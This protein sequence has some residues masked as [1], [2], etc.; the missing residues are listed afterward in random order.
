MSPNSNNLLISE[1][2]R[3]YRS[4]ETTPPQVLAALAAKAAVQPHDP[5]WILRFA[6]H[7]IGAQLEALDSA[8]KLSGSDWAKFPLYGIPFAIKDNIDYAGQQ[9]TAAC[10]QF[11]Y[12]PAESATVVKRL[13]AAGAICVGKTNLDQFATGLNGTRSPYGAV[14]NTFNPLYVSGG[15]SSG[16]AS[17]VARGLVSFSLGTDTAGSGRVP[18]G[19]NNIVGLKPTKGALST[20]GVVPACRSQDCV[21]IFAL[22]ASDAQSV[23]TA[24][25]GADAA[26]IYSR[27]EPKVPPAG[28]TL[29]ANLRV[30]VPQDPEFCGDELAAKS[31]AGALERMQALGAKLVPFDLKPF[32]EVARLLYEGPWVAERFAAIE[33]MFTTKPE[34]IHPVV[35]AVIEK[36]RN[37]TAVDT[38]NAMYRLEALRRQ[39]APMWDQ[40]D[41]M[42]V[43]TSPTIYT[44]EAMLAD[45]VKKNSD[46]GI[47]TN[48]VN[49]L[50]LSAIALPASLR[51][52]GL[53]SGITLI[54]P[55][56]S[57]RAL[58]D[59][60]ARWQASTGLTL[61]AT[62]IAHPAVE[63][64]A[65][66]NGSQSG[67][68]SNSP[69]HGWVRVA[70][71]GAHLSGMP[72]NHQ[73]ISRGAR[74]VSEARTTASYALYALAGT[75]PPKPGLARTS[76][77]AAGPAGTSIAL[78]LWDM[79][80]HRFGEFVAE[81]PAPLGIGNVELVSG[82]WVKGF[83]CEPCGIAGAEDISHFGGWRAYIASKS[84]DNAAGSTAGKPGSTVSI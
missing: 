27:A 43:P 45:P 25:S 17:V 49:L 26:D 48:F 65:A 55:A 3:R 61:G 37:H 75:V 69:A 71:V 82:E 77:G 79:P 7:T 5:A 19:F 2:L 1:L 36:A 56:W 46:F 6:E 68:Q 11:A 63:E 52:D 84:A 44:I 31:Y 41:V 80:M 60:G 32:L 38:F 53:P 18:A 58:C 64:N 39:N 12:V 22:T 83:I 70:V 9:T 54:A 30:G 20:A 42:L 72:L 35:R 78:E 34:A 16:S 81:V 76:K 33:T 15:S 62:G 51:P 40:I 74:L 8:F 4:G 28:F 73:L 14:P 47:Y 66:R 23:W 67:S 21:S 59:V 24:A 13:Q 10:P 57:E 29:G 50:D